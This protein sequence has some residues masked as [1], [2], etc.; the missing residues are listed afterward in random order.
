MSQ[1]IFDGIFE[2]KTV[3]VTGHTGF[4]GSWLTL[5][6]NHLGAN[7]I[8]YSLNPPTNPSLFDILN[9]DNEV[10]NVISDIRD[11]D[12]LFETVKKYEPEF[13]FH[14]A[15][16]SLV[17]YSYENPLDTFEVNV[18]GTAN[19][20]EVL[21]FSPSVKVALIM[22]SDKCYDNKINDHAH[23]E[24]DPMGGIDPY[25][26]SKGA[27]EL[28]TSSYKHSFFDTSDDKISI[29]TIRA[30]NILGG[31]D[32]AKDRIVPD[33]MRAWSKNEIVEIR[34]PNATRP[35]Q[36]VLEPLSGYF[37]LGQQLYSQEN[38]NGESFNFGPSAQHSH[39][40]ED[41][42]KDMSQYW[43][44]K[45]LSKGYQITDDIK[46]H[47]AGLLKLNCDKALFYLKWLPTL[48]YKEFIDFTGSWYFNFYKSQMD[49][50]DFTL[51][52]IDEYEQIAAEK[53]IQWTK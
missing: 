45:D 37:A 12:K 3:L 26:A 31:G 6:L 4:I 49:M 39:T 9:F 48:S 16:Q 43:N 50:L 44:I 18:L 5:W 2:G 28:I 13:V 35:W 29:S 10:T 7:V 52:Q 32:W 1:K 38:I 19:V 51:S 17:R 22:T 24:D 47:E 36:H 23:V 11:K 14:L 20:L 46:F 40:V 15:A 41:I 8:G 30:G 34:S 25:S 27:A 53:G 21:R 33:C 42:L